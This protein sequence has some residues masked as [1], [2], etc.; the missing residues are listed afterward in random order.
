M[1]WLVRFL[2][3]LSMIPSLRELTLGIM[4]AL[5]GLFWVSWSH[6]LADPKRWISVW[7]L[8]NTQY[9]HP[10]CM[11]MSVE[12]DTFIFVATT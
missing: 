12:G 6:K 7:V 1:V 3:V 11:W 9:V 10:A 8:T 2:R 5:H 4:D